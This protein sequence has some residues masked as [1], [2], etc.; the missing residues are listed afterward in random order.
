[1]EQAQDEE[2][3]RRNESKVQ[4]LPLNEVVIKGKSKDNLQEFTIAGLTKPF[5]FIC[6]KTFLSESS[7]PEILLKNCSSKSIQ[8]PFQSL[9][10]VIVNIL[11]ENG[12]QMVFLE[13]A[14]SL[15]IKT[16]FTVHGISFVRSVICLFRIN[17]T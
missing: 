5:R 15:E 8:H 13:T 14:F 12:I 6:L 9:A 11:R 16:V 2:T 1:V 17:F 7:S 3:Y 10:T 4:L